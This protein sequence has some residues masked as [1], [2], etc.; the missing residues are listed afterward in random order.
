MDRTLIGSVECTMEQKYILK[1]SDGDLFREALTRLITTTQF[2]L[3]LEYLIK[4][5]SS[6][7]L[8]KYFD[9]QKK[10]INIGESQR[11]I[12]RC[13]LKISN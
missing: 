10:T 1:L 8:R 7:T 5:V 9:F 3:P 4:E 6:E 12:Y 13:K 11:F 2:L